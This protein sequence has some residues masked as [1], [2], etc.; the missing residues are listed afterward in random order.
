MTGLLAMCR[1]LSL[2]TESTRARRTM[3]P[4]KVAER[5]LV[6]PDWVSCWAAS[7]TSRVDEGLITDSFSELSDEMFDD[8]AEGQHGEVGEADD[9]DGDAGEHQGEQRRAGGQGP[10]R[11]RDS[12]LAAQGSGDG[13]YRYHQGE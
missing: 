11:H 7:G 13:Q 1:G 8:G 5:F 6:P 3:A 2:I 9:D 12:L 10:P 4:L